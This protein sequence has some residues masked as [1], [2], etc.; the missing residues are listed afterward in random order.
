M[1]IYAKKRPPFWHVLHEYQLQSANIYVDVTDNLWMES[2]CYIIQPPRQVHLLTI[3]FFVRSQLHSVPL[4]RLLHL[5]PFSY[6]LISS[7]FF[8]PPGTNSVMT[9]LSKNTPRVE[10]AALTAS[11]QSSSGSNRK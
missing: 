6:F 10:L 7:P 4:L 2:R 9:K 5:L 8:V 3:M 11:I 1:S